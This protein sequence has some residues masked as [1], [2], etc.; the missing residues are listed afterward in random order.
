MTDIEPVWAFSQILRH[1][2]DLGESLTEIISRL[3]RI[4]EAQRNHANALIAVQAEQ[5]S[6][7]NSTDLKRIEASISLLAGEIHGIGV[8]I[9]A[10]R[11]IRANDRK[12]P[13]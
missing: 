11:L 13:P 3:D 12:A 7:A 2:Q 10:M 8:D 6:T 1:V 9:S 5:R 4:E